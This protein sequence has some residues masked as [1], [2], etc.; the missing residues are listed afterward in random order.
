MK[1][2]ILFVHGLNGGSGTW[3]NFERLIKDDPELEY[4]TFFYEY[5]SSWIRIIPWLQEKYGNI[6][7][8]S[9]GLGTFIDHHLDQYDEVVLVGHSLGGLII[10]QYLLNRKISNRPTKVKKVLFYAVPQEGSGLA[11]VTS[12]IS[13]NHGHLK[14]LCNNSEFLDTLNDQWATSRIELDFEFKLVIAIEDGAVSPQSAKSNFRHMELE[15]IAGKDHRSVVKPKNKD[16]LAFKILKNFL[17]MT[18]SISKSRPKGALRF[19]EW[20]LNDDTTGPFFPDS[21]R[22]DIIK[23]LRRALVQPRNA[24]RVTGLSGLGKTRIAVEAIRELSDQVKNSVVYLDVAFEPNDLVATVHKWVSDGA[25]GLLV[26]DNCSVA[27]HDQLLKATLRQESKLTLL[28]LDSDLQNSGACKYVELGRLDDGMIKKMLAHNFGDALPDIDRVVGFAQ[29]F[30]Q[31]AVLIARARIN[32]DPD[33]GKLSDDLFAHKLLWGATQERNATDERILLG[34]ALF[35]RFGLESET[36]SEFQYIAN[37]VV[38]VN[39]SDFYECVKRFSER[40]LIDKRG[41]YAQL[42]PKPLAIRL[43]AQWW[44]RNQRQAQ[45]NLINGMPDSLVTSFCEQIGKLDFLPEVKAFTANL[46]GNQGPFGQAEVILSSRGSRLFRAFVDV[47]P[48]ATSS[49]LYDVIASLDLE[50]LTLIGGDVRRNLVWALEK[51]CFHARLFDESAWTLFLLATAENETWGNNATGIFSQLFRV[52]L[53]G[54]EAEPAIRFSL[55]RKALDLNEQSADMVVLA[56]LKQSINIHGGTRTVGAEYQGTKL[57]LQE[58]KATIWQEIFDF[59]QSAFDILI[60]MTARGK[61]QNDEATEIIGHSIR[62][63]VGNG[64]LSMLDAAIRKIVERNGKY[65]P[66]ALDSIKM[67]FEYDTNGLNQEAIEMLKEWSKLLDA[68]DSP[69]LEKLMILVKNPPW[70]HREN[71]QGEYIDVAAE[72]AKLLAN[73][74]SENLESLKEYIPML[75]EGEQKQAYSFGEKIAELT[76]YY[77]DF[78]DAVLSAI[79]SADRPN[80]N[81]CLGMFSGIFKKSKD[82]WEVRIELIS[83]DESLQKF[84]PNF[85]RTGGICENHLNRL[86]ELIEEGNLASEDAGVLFYG[87]VTSGIDLEVI[88]NFCI[89]LSKINDVGAWVALNVLYMYCHG[90]PGKFEA[91]RLYFRE[92]TTLVL[93]GKEMSSRTDIHS[94]NTVVKKLLESED[95]VYAALICKKIIQSA[96]GGLN[97]SDIWHTIK[98]LL[99]IIMKKHGRELW[100][101]FTS[102][103]ASAEATERYWLQQLLERENGISSQQVSVLSIIPEDVIINWCETAEKSILLFVAASINIFD[104]A[105]LEKRPTALVVALLEKFAGDADFENTLSANMGS[106]GWSGSLVPYLESDKSGLSHLLTNSNRKVRAWAKKKIGYIDKEIEH[107]SMRDDEQGLGIY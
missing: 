10:R 88:S 96:S 61:T 24:V 53:S 35:D 11:K 40:G 78:V 47:N 46:C 102:A 72:N 94:W 103:I 45:E 39:E 105:G 58:W 26:V 74:L 29:G 4:S 82:D 21:K 77:D 66:S 9:S 100:P 56:A 57:P 22:E 32:L 80:I 75:L 97:H 41:R 63:F 13:Y 48:D 71:E 60:E 70:E 51:L 101:I 50:E 62:A 33:I 89:K 42:V 92:L 98:P 1:K 49:A 67:V 79:K 27:L 65:W 31:M 43:A 73:E 69:L 36:S 34:C 106:R 54:T 20:L 15:Q 8:L 85:I 84:Y 68:K 95:V 99:M 76:T 28:S 14:Q 7:A 64:R 2:A 52:Q 17:L 86:L 38:N 12:L 5:P 87:S 19:D 18:I 55:I 90:N 6:Q 37:Q 23:D 25:G 3:G 44:G 93:L 59:W 16:D 91:A 83:R 30:P 107:E 104:G 81:F